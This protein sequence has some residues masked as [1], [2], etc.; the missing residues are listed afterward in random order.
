MVMIKEVEAAPG[1]YGMQFM[2]GQ[3]P[4]ESVTRG[5]AGAMKPVF[6]IIHSVQVEN[7]AQAAFVERAV[8]RDQRHIANGGSQFLPYFREKRGLYGIVIRKPVDAGIEFG[9]IIR[10]GAYKSVQFV[11]HLPFAHHYYPH[12]AYAGALPVGGLEIYGGKIS[13]W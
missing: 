1:R 3:E 4:A 2:V 13:H 12:A 6:G 5:P 11:G 10:P 8:M 7:R 9:I